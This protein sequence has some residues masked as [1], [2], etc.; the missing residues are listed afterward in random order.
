MMD[1]LM[2]TIKNTWEPVVIFVLLSTISAREDQ[3]EFAINSYKK[4]AEAWKSGEI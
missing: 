1:L 4:A 3:D 2:C